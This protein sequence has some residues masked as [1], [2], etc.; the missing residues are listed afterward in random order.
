MYDC[1]Y[2]YYYVQMNGIYSICECLNVGKWCTLADHIHDSL[3]I[4][5]YNIPYGEYIAT[6]EQAPLNLQP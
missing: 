1:M 4:Y 2:I 6:M 5:N 3:V